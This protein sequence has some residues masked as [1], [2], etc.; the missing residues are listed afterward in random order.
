MRTA[1]S[2]VLD[3]TRALVQR[4]T[5]LQVLQRAL[6]YIVMIL[7]MHVVNLRNARSIPL[8]LKLRFPRRPHRRRRGRRRNP[9]LQRRRRLH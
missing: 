3:I 2:I 6:I 4:S 5:F 1:E 9:A 8:Q 7:K